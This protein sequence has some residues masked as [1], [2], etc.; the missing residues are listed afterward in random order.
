[1]QSTL[2]TLRQLTSDIINRSFPQLRD[3]KI[4]VFTGP[5]RFYAFSVWVPPFFR[6]IVISTRTLDFNRKVLTGLIA[7]ELCHQERYIGMGVLNY[8]VFAVKFL[9]LKKIRS[10]EEK[11]TDRLTIEKGYG[12]ELYELSTITHKDR[13]HKKINDLY[14]SLEEIRAYSESLGNWV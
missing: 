6:V 10:A 11:A 9:T 13:K 8:L 5:L 1:M 14:L 2:A 7:H 12:R 4:H 3:K